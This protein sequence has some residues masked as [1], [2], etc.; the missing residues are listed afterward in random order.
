MEALRAEGIVLRKQPVTESSLVVTWF[1]REA[2]KLK[3]LAKGARRTKGP[4]VGKLDLF[5]HDEIVYLPSRQSDL[6]L[7]TDCFVVEPHRRLR[8]S[9]RTLTAAS[10]ACE[11]VETITMDGDPQP[12]VLELLAGVLSALEEPVPGLAVLTWLELRLLVATGWAPQWKGR[13]GVERVLHSLVEANL[14]GA[15]RVRLSAAQVQEARATVW[16]FWDEHVEKAPRSRAVL[17]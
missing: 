8:S 7:L 15:R 11:L 2:G 14:A 17:G 3:T 6:H 5:Y 9:V 10:Y 13:S 12:E 16:R 1:T 4:F